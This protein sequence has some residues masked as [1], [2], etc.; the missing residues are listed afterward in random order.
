MSEIHLHITCSWRGFSLCI[1]P[2]ECYPLFSGKLGYM[3]NILS[4]PGPTSLV[5]KVPECWAFKK[6]IYLL[7]QTVEEELQGEG[8]A[9]GAKANPGKSLNCFCSHLGFLSLPSQMLLLSPADLHFGKEERTVL[10]RH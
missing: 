4:L 3:I 10:R 2:A 5:S 9:T 1:T 7:I 8:T 6:C